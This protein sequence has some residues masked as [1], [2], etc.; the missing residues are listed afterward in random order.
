M[1]RRFNASHAKNC[2]GEV[3]AQGGCVRC[4]T[5]CDAR[6]PYHQ[7]NPDV[8]LVHVPLVNGEAELPHVV[9]VVRCKD[10]KGVVEV[11]DLVEDTVYKVINRE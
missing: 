1:I 9:P 8:K 6:A 2:R 7:R 4:S 3:D 10:D 11:R 5:A